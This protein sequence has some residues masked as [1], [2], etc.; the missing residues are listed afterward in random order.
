[1]RTKKP[2]DPKKV[3]LA[4]AEA[5]LDKKA[6]EVEIIDVSGK[7]D[8]AD[9]LVL[10]SGSTDRHVHAIAESI[11]SAL[12]KKRTSLLGIEGLPQ[13]QWVLMDFGDVVAHI[14][15]GELRTYYD[16]EGLW[17]DAQRI[18]VPGDGAARGHAAGS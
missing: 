1:M 12:E 15:C 8:Y 9:Y 5:A 2:L 10:A 17:I 7:V 4:I 14:F 11:E 13:A 18:P 3:A 16:L 6:L